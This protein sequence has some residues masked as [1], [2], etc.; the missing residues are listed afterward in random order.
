MNIEPTTRVVRLLER[1]LTMARDGQVVSLAGAAQL[2]GGRTA[3]FVSPSA[4]LGVG[5]LIG[6]LACVQAKLVEAASV[7]EMVL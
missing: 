6:E 4:N 2:T 7:Q 3:Q 5:P 1:L